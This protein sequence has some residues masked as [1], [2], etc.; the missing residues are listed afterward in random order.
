MYKYIYIY[1]S[2]LILYIY[3]CTSD[4]HNGILLN[5]KKEWNNTICSKTD[6]SRD[7]HTKWSKPDRDK[8]HMDNT[9]MWTLKLKRCKWTYF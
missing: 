9:C 8:Y 3:I 4:I 7:F 5:H 6:G 1:I 2:H